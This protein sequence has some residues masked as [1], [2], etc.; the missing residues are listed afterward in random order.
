MVYSLA[1]NIQH[2]SLRYH[3][4]YSFLVEVCETKRTNVDKLTMYLPNLKKIKIFLMIAKL[5]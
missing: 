5:L 2:L 1:T 3:F 4:V